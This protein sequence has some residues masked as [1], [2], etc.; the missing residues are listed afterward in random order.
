VFPFDQ[1]T[2]VGVNLAEHV[3]YLKLISR[4]VISKFQW[5]LNL[6]QTDGQT[7]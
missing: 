6:S 7:T 2:H 5:N 3:G 1:I 4:E